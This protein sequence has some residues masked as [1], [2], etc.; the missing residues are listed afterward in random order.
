MVVRSGFFFVGRGSSWFTVGVGGH[1]RERAYGVFYVRK[2]PPY[3][4]CPFP[5]REARYQDGHPTPPRPQPFPVPA[6]REIA[7]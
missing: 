1:E 3:H 5:R 7:K 6:A 2:H 4:A